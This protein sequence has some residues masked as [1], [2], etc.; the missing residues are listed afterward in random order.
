MDMNEFTIK[1][2]QQLGAVLRGFR[3]SKKLNQQAVGLKAALPQ[4]VISKV[5]SNSGRITLARLFKVLAALD[6]ELVVRPKS[7][8]HES[9]EW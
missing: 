6:L 3:N 2:P 1:T 5:E 8:K 4:P 7:K 9:S